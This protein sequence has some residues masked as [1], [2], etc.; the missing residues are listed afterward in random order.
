MPGHVRVKSPLRQ[1][2][3]QRWLPLKWLFQI[4]LGERDQQPCTKGGYPRYPSFRQSKNWEYL[5]I[6]S[7]SPAKIDP[8]AFSNGHCPGGYLMF[9][10]KPSGIA[11]G[12]CHLNQQYPSIVWN[13]AAATKWGHVWDMCG[14]CATLAQASRS[15]LSW[16]CGLVWLGLLGHAG[17]SWC[18]IPD[19]WIFCYTIH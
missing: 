15:R 2:V 13:K 8:I 19:Q 1:R 17:A 18:R 4:Q 3:H 9:L 6:A 5:G 11:I 16:L 7:F 12:H 14:H 10:L